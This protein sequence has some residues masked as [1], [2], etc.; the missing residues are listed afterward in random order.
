[1]DRWVFMRRRFVPDEGTGRDGILLFLLFILSALF[2]VAVK[3]VPFTGAENIKREMT[4]A[5]EIMDRGL[6]VIR[7][8]RD[9]KGIPVNPQNDPNRTGLIGPKY[10]PLTT[11]LGQLEAKRTTTNPNFAALVVFLLRKAGI[12]RGDTIAVAASG[13]F[14]A[15]IL[16][17]LSASRALD[18]KP[19]VISSLGASQWGANHPRF[20]W[21]RMHECLVKAGVFDNKPAALSLGGDRDR[22][23]DMEEEMRA[24][25]IREIEESG[26]L[27]LEEPNLER[28][29]QR[30]VF[31]YLKYADK[32]G[33]KALVNIGGS[34][35]SMGSDPEVLRLK[36]GL[37]KVG[38]IPP[39]ERRGLIHEMASRG[40]PVI[41]L[42]Y[43]KGL[44]QS[45]GLPWDP[46]PL[47]RPGEGNLYDIPRKEQPE[48]LYIV[49]SYLF[50]IF[51]VLILR[52]VL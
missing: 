28:N 49:T 13:S 2:F 50:L 21:L 5:S 31:L 1:M 46:V 11:S 6:G 18:L 36:P 48:F 27:F 10:S 26:I 34:W 33:I 3:V 14:P 52:K 42:L 19:V 9:E 12:R 37:I 30:R 4:A 20:H 24:R 39:P 8:C 51:L 25:L 35:T 38:R 32:M 16:A 45:F 41:H 23:E 22:G 7:D 17:A 43:I 44:V 29:V 15:L 40:I 47:P